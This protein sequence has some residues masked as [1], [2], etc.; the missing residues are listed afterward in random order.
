MSDENRCPWCGVQVVGLTGSGL[1]AGSAGSAAAPAAVAAAAAAAVAAAAAAAPERTSAPTRGGIAPVH[2]LPLTPPP[3]Q[4]LGARGTGRPDD[5]GS[6]PPPTVA[7]G[8]LAS[9][10]WPD[11]DAAVRAQEEEREHQ[12]AATLPPEARELPPADRTLLHV[13]AD[14]QAEVE[15]VHTVAHRE[16]SGTKTAIPSGN[17]AGGAAER[18]RSPSSAGT[19]MGSTTLSPAGGGPLCPNCARPLIDTRIGM[20]LDRYRID[21]LLGQGGMG[22]VYKATHVELG[23]PV[24]VKFL[25]ASSAQSAEVRTRFKR[26]AVA[27]ARLRHPGIVA[28]HDF[29]HW[30]DSPYIVMEFLDGHPL[31]KTIKEQKDTLPLPELWKIFDQILEVLEAAHAR[32]IVHRDLKPDNVML[33]RTTDRSVHVKVLDFGLAIVAESSDQKLTVAGQVFGTPRYMSPEQCQGISVGAPTDIYAFGTMLYEALTGKTPF[34]G[35]MV[36]LLSQHLFGAPPPMVERGLQRPIP[37]GIEPLV[38]RALAKKVQDR[39]T[40]SELRDLLGRAF[41]EVDAAASGAHAAEQKVVAGSL[42]RDQRA[43][44]QPA[45]TVQPTGQVAV[46]TVGDGPRILLWMGGSERAGLLR[47]GL[48]VAGCVVATF[49]GAALPAEVSFDPA[50]TDGY[51]A[52]V[53]SA[54]EAGALE[55]LTAMRAA[56]ATKKVPVV[57]MGVG[58]SAQMSPFIRAGASEV[59]LASVTDEVMSQKIVKAAK[60]GRA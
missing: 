55:R 43:L 26:E 28:V 31:S 30:E 6:A 5:E 41:K 4:A 14:A 1:V 7:P 56:D 45:K 35:P 49:E 18:S 22:R 51:R 9:Q 57:V 44:A 11:L 48:A 52:V 29:G 21:S 23:E 13:T 15:S 33:L 17:T 2:G 42:S 32:G 16:A 12:T 54:A 46:R 8:M 59:V 25:L 10:I 19:R 36:R 50:R 24:V 38:N 39:P 60:R 58:A 37:P 3:E 40:A 20:S 27:L 34:E 47:D 53:L